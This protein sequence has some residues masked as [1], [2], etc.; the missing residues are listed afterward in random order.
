MDDQPHNSRLANKKPHIGLEE[1]KVKC[2]AH[3]LNRR[4]RFDEFPN[5]S[6]LYC[7]HTINVV[8]LCA[9]FH[10]H[11]FAS[12]LSCWARL[13]VDLLVQNVQYGAHAGHIV[14]PLIYLCTILHTLA[15]VCVCSV[16]Y[17]FILN[18]KFSNRF[19]ENCER[20]CWW[21]VSALLLYLWNVSN[22]L[23]AAWIIIWF[24]AQLHSMYASACALNPRWGFSSLTGRAFGSRMFLRCAAF[25]VSENEDG[26]YS[27][28]MKLHTKLDCCETKTTKT[29]TTITTTT[30]A[31]TPR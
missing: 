8:V 22:M 17:V 6:D 7:N 21:L 9:L 10:I 28:W 24:G 18:Y 27:I 31:K 29:T 15:G 4:S 25:A 16:Y 19:D 12:V 2:P 5:K 13:N 14:V 11:L 3:K 23:C 20:C 30:A 1:R 26:K